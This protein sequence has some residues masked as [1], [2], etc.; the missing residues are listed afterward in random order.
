MYYCNLQML[1][2][3]TRTAQASG[4]LGESPPQATEQRWQAAWAAYGCRTILMH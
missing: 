4:R 2:E 3:Y 1:E